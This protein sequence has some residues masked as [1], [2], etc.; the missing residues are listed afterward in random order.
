MLCMMLETS[1][2]E[3]ENRDSDAHRMSQAEWRDRM[4]PQH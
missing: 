3:I 1:G 4:R 2:V